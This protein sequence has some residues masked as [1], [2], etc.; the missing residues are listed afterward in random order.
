V[1]FAFS[2]TSFYHLVQQSSVDKEGK[3]QLEIEITV[4]TEALNS[5]E[6]TERNFLLMSIAYSANI[7]G[8]GVV[9]GS[10]REVTGGNGGGGVSDSSKRSQVVTER[11]RMVTRESQVVLRGHR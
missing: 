1:Y 7:G 4:D 2:V 11:S 6:E 5:K 3:E 9:T 8:T 10:N